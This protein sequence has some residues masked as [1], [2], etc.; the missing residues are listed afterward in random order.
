MKPHRITS[1]GFFQLFGVS[2]MYKQFIVL[3][4]T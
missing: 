1:G 3:H 4:L 2:E